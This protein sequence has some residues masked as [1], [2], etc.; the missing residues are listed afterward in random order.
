MIGIF[1]VTYAARAD[2]A[3]WYPYDLPHAALFTAGCLAILEG[4]WA[5]IIAVFL[6]DTPLRET[7]IYL[8]PCLLLI[9]RVQRRFR[10]AIVISLGLALVW[11]VIRILITRHFQHNPTDLQLHYYHDSQALRWPRHWP[12]LTTIFGF[13]GLPLLVK[14]DLLTAS[15]RALLLAAL[16]CILV[17][18]YFGIWYETRVWLEWNGIIACLAFFAFIHYLDQQ[19]AKSAGALGIAAERVAVAR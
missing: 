11:L 6:I 5:V 7:S 17:S 13:L 9:G 12:Q 15:H 4:Y 19:Q 1:Y 3:V 2:Q 16:P 18:A 14:R 10:E 8:V